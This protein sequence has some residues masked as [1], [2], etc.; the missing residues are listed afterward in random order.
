MQNGD[1]EL[2]ALARID[3]T[4]RGLLNN[5][6]QVALPA[7]ASLAADMVSWLGYMEL[8]RLPEYADLLHNER[9]KVQEGEN[10]A[11]FVGRIW[12]LLSPN[13]RGIALQL[14]LEKTITMERVSSTGIQLRVWR[15]ADSMEWTHPPGCHD[16]LREWIR[17]TLI[18]EL[19]GSSS[20]ATH[21]ANVVETVQ[22]LSVNRSAFPEYMEENDLESWEWCFRSPYYRRMRSV[23][24]KILKMQEAALNDVTGKIGNEIDELIEAVLD[25]D[26]DV[27]DLEKKGRQSPPL[28]PIIAMEGPNRDAVTGEYLVYMKLTE[29]Q[30]ILFQRKMS[31]DMEYKLEGED[32]SKHLLVQYRDWEGIWNCRMWID[33][34]WTDWVPGSPSLSRGSFDTIAFQDNESNLVVL[35]YWEEHE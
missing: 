15:A 31:S 33:D 1:K 22:W 13:Q 32:Y 2:R 20:S 29:A 23:A 5:D 26:Q 17:Y 9:L 6:P 7:T 28:P 34:A 16:T 10:S 25:P 8:V 11:T 12:S 18:S 14:G 19:D 30:R 3:D 4:P 27:K 24:G 35:N 21:L